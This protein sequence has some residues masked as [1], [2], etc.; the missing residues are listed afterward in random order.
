MALAPSGEFAYLIYTNSGTIRIADLRGRTVST[1][2]AGEDLTNLALSPSGDDLYLTSNS[3]AGDYDRSFYVLD[4]SNNKVIRNVNVGGSSST[5][6]VSPDGRFLYVTT[7][8]ALKIISAT[9]LTVVGSIPLSNGFGAANSALSVNGNTVYVATNQST[10]SSGSLDSQLDVIDVTDRKVLATIDQG[11]KI[12]GPCGLVT[13]TTRSVLYESTCAAE[14]GAGEADLGLLIFDEKTNRFEAGIKLN[15]GFRGI[16]LAPKGNVLYAA[17]DELGGVDLIDVATRKL[18]EHVSV[19]TPTIR[20]RFGPLKTGL[21]D[22]SVSRNGRY[23]YAT[24][25]TFTNNGTLSAIQ[26]SQSR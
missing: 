18:I 23:L 24:N 3:P 14:S 10:G 4:T 21:Y 20:T 13:S 19:S 11:K 12:N 9:T 16:A 22:L 7:N 17:N 26:L 5:V 6:V 2:H 1:T 25:F 15:G 8:D